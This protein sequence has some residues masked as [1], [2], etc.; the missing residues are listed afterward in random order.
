MHSEGFPFLVWGLGA[1]PVFA[2]LLPSGLGVVAGGSLIP[3]RGDWPRACRVGGAVP[4]GLLV[5]VSRVWRCAVMIADQSSGRRRVG[6]AVSLGLVGR[7]S[8]VPETARRTDSPTTD[9]RL[10]KVITD[11]TPA[12]PQYSR[13]YYP[14]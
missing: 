2:S 4:W 14:Y 12:Q 13:H 3:C 10:L 1:G 7:A 8:W 5:A 11:Y 9:R 6:G